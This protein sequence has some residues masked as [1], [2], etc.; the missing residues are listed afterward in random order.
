MP[1][2]SEFPAL[3]EHIQRG[4]LDISVEDLPMIAPNEQRMYRYAAGGDA[5]LLEYCNN[6]NE[7][8]GIA[9]G[10]RLAY[11]DTTPL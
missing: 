8:V 1:T 11:S 10:Y 7:E 5:M 9:Q 4:L 3:R 2:S 6:L